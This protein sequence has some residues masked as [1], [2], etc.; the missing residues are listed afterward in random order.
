MKI[1]D[2]LSFIG[3]GRYK[4][5]SVEELIQR[6]DQ[7]GVEKALI[8]PVDEYVVAY[9]KATC[10]CRQLALLTLIGLLDM[11]WQIPGLEIKLLIPL[12]EL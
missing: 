5:Q 9:K 8:A 2:S 11:Q 10:L 6:M 1:I 7:N 12:S 4:N 3:Q